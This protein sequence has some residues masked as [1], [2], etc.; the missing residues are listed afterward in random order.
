MCVVVGKGCASY[1]IIFIVV[2]CIERKGRVCIVLYCMKGR[3]CIVRKGRYELE[4]CALC[5]MKGW[6]AGGVPSVTGTQSKGCVTRAL[7]VL[8][9]IPEEVSAAGAGAGGGVTETWRRGR[10]NSNSNN[11]NNAR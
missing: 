11:N 9:S 7:Q 2:Y 6:V 5:C 3:V 1:C 8:T 10:E 4:G